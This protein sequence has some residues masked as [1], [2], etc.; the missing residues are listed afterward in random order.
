MSW[1]EREP[2]HTPKD[3]EDKH[4]YQ[5]ERDHYSDQAGH[6]ARSEANDPKHLDHWKKEEKKL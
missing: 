5:K 1:G 4:D 3:A 2:R 6:R